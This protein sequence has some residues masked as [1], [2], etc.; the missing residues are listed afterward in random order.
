MKN[1]YKSLLALAAVFAVTGCGQPIFYADLDEPA[2]CKT[3]ADVPFDPTTPGADLKLDFDLPVGQY[4]PGIFEGNDAQVTLY[5]NEIVFNA[6]QGITDFNSVDNASISVL[7]PAGADPSLQTALLLNYT[8]DP[9][10]LPGRTLTVGG[11]RNVELFPYLTTDK[12]KKARL[13]AVMQGQLPPNIW[14][15]DVRVCLHMKAHF[16]YAKQYGF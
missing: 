13:E 7:P 9:A 3:V 4:L 14:T 2:L 1:A 8:K 11:E 15:A 12:D 16:N 6:K 10:N 5:L